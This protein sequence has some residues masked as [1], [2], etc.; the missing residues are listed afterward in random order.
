MDILGVAV[1]QMQ[2]ARRHLHLAKSY[3]FC[4]GR[5]LPHCNYM[6]ILPCNLLYY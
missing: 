6:P 5:A 4:V 2:G 3:N 1:R